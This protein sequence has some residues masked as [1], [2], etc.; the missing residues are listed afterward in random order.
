[1]LPSLGRGKR[2]LGNGARDSRPPVACPAH[3]RAPLTTLSSCSRL[4]LV[5]RTV[6]RRPFLSMR[7]LGCILNLRWPLTWRVSSRLCC[8]MLLLPSRGLENIL[9][10]LLK[11]IDASSAFVLPQ[12]VAACR[13][14]PEQVHY[15]CRR[16]SCTRGDEALTQLCVFFLFCFFV[17]LLC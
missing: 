8:D 4:A 7:V 9:E 14:A 16:C 15:A 10:I 12:C 13:S 11:A 2:I 5:K 6:S 1:M 3:F 17:F